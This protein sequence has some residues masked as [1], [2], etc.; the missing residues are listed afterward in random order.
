MNN[1]FRPRLVQ[2]RFHILA[3]LGAVLFAF[4]ALIISSVKAQS[5]Q[6]RSADAFVNSIGVA[7][8]LR[9]LDTPYGKYNSIVKPRL[10]EL[11]V[12]HIRDGGSEPAFLDKLN[13][14]ASIGIRSTLVMDPRDG[15]EPSDAVTIAK[16]VANSVEAIEG[17]NETDLNKFSYNGV[18]FPEGTRTYQQALHT[19]IKND[20]ETTALPVLMPSMGWAVNASK[21]GFLSS[22]DTGNMHS[23]PGSQP[24]T[25]HLDDR[26]I[27]NAQI[28]CGTG[29]PIVATETG[30]QNAI[31]NLQ[32]KPAISEKAS[33]KYVPRLFLEYFNRQIRQTFVYELI[34]EK[35][36]DNP[37]W[38]FG[39][40][41]YDGSPKPAF[42]TLKRLMQLLTD[43]GPNFS[44]K[45]LNYQL[46]GQLSNVHHTL[47]QKRD[48]TFYL[49][50]W[51]EVKS[52][53]KVNKKDIIIADRAITLTLNTAIREA[54]IYRPLNSATPVK[55]YSSPRQI[56]LK[57]PDH[58][59][60]L[61]LTSG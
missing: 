17:P 33:G 48:G 13:D 10:K 55:L 18:P 49:I 5:E 34:N 23:Y 29:K 57:V 54:A 51:Q 19:A 46:S 7:V 45:S 4:T 50:L 32:S 47:L 20:P 8:H 30:Y 3:L 26:Y 31:A 38:N 36:G 25:H 42:R 24:P 2:Y 35:E 15:I 37:E 58:P 11:G 41:R 22:C 60:V 9:Y 28:V 43:P 27:P 40:L 39:L 1:F 52:W 21:L 53:D 14:L 12:R 44:L 16:T 59:L 61:K 6:A 56:A